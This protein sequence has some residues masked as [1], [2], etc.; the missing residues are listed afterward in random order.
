MYTIPTLYGANTLI[1]QCIYIII[2]RGVH[3]GFFEFYPQR[4]RLIKEGRLP[5]N[6]YET[7]YNE[8]VPLI[9]KNGSVQPYTEK[10][11][12]LLLDLGSGDHYDIINKGAIYELNIEDQADK[13]S[14][15]FHHLA[16]FKPGSHWA[17]LFFF[18]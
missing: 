1:P 16:T 9:F 2:A 3:I 11:E 14:S 17:P 18:L 12:P 5:S 10:T 8:F 15:L 13:I 6:F 7:Y 4:D